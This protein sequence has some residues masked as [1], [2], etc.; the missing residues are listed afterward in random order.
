M[1]AFDAYCPTP[2][3]TVPVTIIYDKLYD[4]SKS[5]LRHYNVAT[6]TYSPVPGAVFGTRTVGGS[7]RTIVT[8]NITDGGALDTDGVANGIIKDPVGFAVAPTVPTTGQQRQ[9]NIS[10]GLFS[11]FGVLALFIVRYLRKTSYSRK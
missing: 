5:V 8:Y 11:L 9:N 10:T 1:T 2:G 4:T 6:S 3:A 7:V